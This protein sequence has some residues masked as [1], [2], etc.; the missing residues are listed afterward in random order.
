MFLKDI[1]EIKN[2]RYIMKDTTINRKAATGDADYIEFSKFKQL[3]DDGR[4]EVDTWTNIS[5]SH[6]TVQVRSTSTRK[7]SSLHV[8]N[9]P[10]SFKQKYHLGDEA[11]PVSGI[12]G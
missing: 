12:R 10:D 4:I 3:I 8:E 6:G 1:K 7:L 9:I 2:G 5:G 11:T